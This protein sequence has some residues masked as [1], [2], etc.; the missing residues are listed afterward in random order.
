MIVN[1]LADR[2]NDVSNPLN[3]L[4]LS[5][6]GF[7]VMQS[8]GGGAE[9]YSRILAT[10][11]RKVGVAVTT[12]SVYTNDAHVTL[13]Q[14]NGPMSRLYDRSIIRG[15]E[16][17]KKAYDIDLVHANILDQPNAWAF[18]LAAQRLRLP[19][20]TTVHSYVHVCPTEYFVRLPEFIP[21]T[22]PYP[23]A[24]CATCIA[25]VAASH[26]GHG[27]RKDTSGA[28]SLL[29]FGRVPYNMAIFRR[30]LQQ[31]RFVISPSKAYSQ[32]L[33]HVGIAS[34]P[35]NNPID[36][37]GEVAHESDGSVLFIGR[38]EWEKGI[39]VIVEMAKRLPSVP[40]HVVGRGEMSGWLKEHSPDNVVIHGFVSE[41]EKKRLLQRCAVVVVP[42]LWSEMFCYVGLEAFASSKPV[43]SFD[44]G[45]P[46]E[47]IESSGAGLRAIPF[48]IEDFTLNV[49]FLLR[50]RD[51]A[52]EMGAK[53]RRWI[54]R[55][56]APAQ[57]AQHVRRIYRSVLARDHP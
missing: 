12:A 46:K 53:G 13:P 48:S 40:F 10:E 16:R 57:Y 7:S 35:L 47:Q 9:V 55:S 3:V 17:V 22:T 24:H 39:W 30:F 14:S 43:V 19:Y 23:N 41:A 1:E 8:H 38:V 11:L 15:L 26:H 28:R 49:R 54:E 37:N 52:Q 51:T 18:V 50:N 27:C 42:S 21:C 5:D 31:A 4:I 25:S 56:L 44:I 32:L 36:R 6:H 29:A 33:L 20:V 45:G 2:S 34:L